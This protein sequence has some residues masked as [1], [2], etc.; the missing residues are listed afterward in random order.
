MN[1][2]ELLHNEKIVKLLEK[3]SKELENL[4]KSDEDFSYIF[5]S[6]ILIGE[7]F[8]QNA[9]R[10]N[11]AEIILKKKELQD[12]VEEK[13]ENSQKV[14]DWLEKELIKNKKLNYGNI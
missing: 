10:S 3:V 14:I 9:N 1:L 13:D 8:L 6:L 11:S 4:K 12:L 7:M 2:L 5:P